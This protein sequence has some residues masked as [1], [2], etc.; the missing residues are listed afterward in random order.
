ML[1]TICQWT[2]RGCHTN[3]NMEQTENISFR[4]HLL[5]VVVASYCHF[6]RSLH[7]TT[8]LG[9]IL[10]RE[11]RMARNGSCTIQW[12]DSR[13]ENRKHKT[14]ISTVNVEANVEAKTRQKKLSN[15]SCK[16][17]CFV[18]VVAWK[19][20]AFW[21][22]T[23]AG[24]WYPASTCIATHRPSWHTNPLNLNSLNS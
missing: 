16:K 6:L 24:C 7:F 10:R 8:L 23:T 9:I 3:P 19:M 5:S 12:L 2:P 13:A 20:S 14:Q 22:L 4:D 17:H 18:R 21:S 11:C 1:Q 15:L